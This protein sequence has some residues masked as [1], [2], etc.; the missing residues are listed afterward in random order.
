MRRQTANDRATEDG[1]RPDDVLT[2]DFLPI[3]VHKT[4]GSGTGSS[5]RPATVSVDIDTVLISHQQGSDP[6]EVIVP[7]RLFDGVMVQI[8]PGRE[9]GA[10]IA[11]LILKHADQ[12]LSIVLVETE[13]PEQ[14]AA[15]WPAWSRRLDLPMLVC[16]LG[17]KVKPIEAFQAM[18]SGIPSPRRKLRLLTG[19]R[20]RFLVRR[21]TGAP[22]QE[23]VVITGERE[24]IARS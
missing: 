24:I 20:P 9:P 10:V 19:R 22:V 4:L 16:D 17:G 18:P 23:P 8:M 5:G 6:V 7:T 2:P 13:K 14:L 11:R 15:A 3:I 12:D 1:V 21:R